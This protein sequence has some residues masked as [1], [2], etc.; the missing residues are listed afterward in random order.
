MINNY[1]I[2]GIIIMAQR[3]Y[4]KLRMITNLLN[5]YIMLKIVFGYNLL[6]YAPQGYLSK[7]FIFSQ[8]KKLIILIKY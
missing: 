5:F 8:T 7:T 6:T 2:L 4:R 1:D 3:C